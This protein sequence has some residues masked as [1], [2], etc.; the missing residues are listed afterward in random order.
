ML[1]KNLENP[2]GDI[3][4]DRLGSACKTSQ[5]ASALSSHGFPRDHPSIQLA[6]NLRT[7]SMRPL[8]TIQQRDDH[9]SVQQHWLHRP[10]PFR[11]LLFEPRSEIPES[12]FPKPITLC[13]FLV[14]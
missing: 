10:K 4:D 7:G 13:F 9:A 3:L 12:N 11:C 5:E 1:E 6:D 14:T 8:A 2:S